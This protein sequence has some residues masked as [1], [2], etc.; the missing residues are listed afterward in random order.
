MNFISLLLYDFALQLYAIGVKVYSPFNKKAKQWSEGRK[1]I[2]KQIEEWIKPE[3]KIIWVH[4]ASVGEFEQ[5]R[6]VIEM[7]K[8]KYPQ[9]KICLTFFSPSGYELRRRF[10]GADYIFYLPLDS[11]HNAKEFIRITNPRLVIFVKYEFWYHYLNE[12]HNRKIPVLLVS[13]I[14][15]KD[16]LFFRWYGKGFR[17]LLHW[18]KQIFVQEENSLKLLQ[19]YRLNNTTLSSDTRF[20]RVSFIA[21]QVIPIPTIELFKGEN[22]IIIGGST[23][24]KDDEL[25]I[26]Y[27]NENK[28]P[29]LKF[30]IVPHEIDRKYINSIQQKI[31]TTSVAFSKVNKQTAMLSNVLIVDKVGILSSLY[32]YAHIAY[33]G[34]GFGK[35]I[36]N[37]LEAAVFGAPVIFG[38]N[39]KRFKEATD[40]IELNSGFSINDYNGFAAITNKLITDEKLYTQ[41]SEGCKEYVKANTGATQQIAEYL[42]ENFN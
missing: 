6:P 4:C 21:S 10:A 9:Y 22:K 5:G 35:G 17:K 37:I 13:A 16:Q 18:Y 26:Q 33:V 12:L 28:N 34:G 36:H 23:W 1:N 42:S 2:L 8:E 41:S 15:R 24:Q 7:L 19:K 11:K 32:Y 40:L 3:D 25:L 27:I 20:D 31:Q 14:F 38:P 29:E 30:I 39:Y